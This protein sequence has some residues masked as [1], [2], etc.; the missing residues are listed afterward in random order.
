[1]DALAPRRPG[2]VQG[3]Q[4]VLF[5]NLLQDAG[6]TGAQ[7]GVEQD[8]AGVKVFHTQPPFA[9]DHRLQRD[10]VAVGQLD[11]GGFC[12]ARVDGANAHI[13]PGHV[14]NLPQAR[15]IGEV[16]GALQLVVRDDQQVARFRADFLDSGHRRLHRQWQ[17]LSRQVVPTARKQVGFGW[18]QFEARIA[19]IDRAVKRRRVLHPLQAKPALNRR[20][21]IQHALLKL[22]DGASQGGNQVRNHGV[23]S[24]G[25]TICRYRPIVAGG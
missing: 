19:Q 21:R 25:G 4:Q 8:R 7:V 2:R 3:R 20:H 5:M 17:H 12:D 23:L 14:K 22:I 24:E 6:H 16:E 9:A 11:R 18:R 10:R 1:M 13:E 15:Y